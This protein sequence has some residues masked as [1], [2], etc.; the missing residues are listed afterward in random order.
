MAT[1]LDQLSPTELV[2]A[3]RQVQEAFTSAHYPF[4][5]DGLVAAVADGVGHAD[6]VSITG[7]RGGKFTTLAA[8]ND[9]ARSADQLPYR[10]REGLP[11]RHR[12]R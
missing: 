9:L 5:E 11:G 3:Y 7:W 1:L 12:R 4:T 6:A 8:S 10:L 2:E